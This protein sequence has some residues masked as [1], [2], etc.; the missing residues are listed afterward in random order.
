MIIII[1]NND[2]AYKKIMMIPNDFDNDSIPAIIA[3]NQDIET[4]K[5]SI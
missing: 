4:S 1:N 2:V 5:F 3:D